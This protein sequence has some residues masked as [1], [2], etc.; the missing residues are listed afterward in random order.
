[1]VSN[2]TFSHEDLFKNNNIDVNVREIALQ[3][4]HMGVM[5]KYSDIIL[6]R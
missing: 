2:E 4:M 6:W 5:L 1:M 3:N